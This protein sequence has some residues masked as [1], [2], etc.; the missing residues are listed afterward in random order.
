MATLPAKF[1]LVMESAK[2]QLK[3]VTR[4]L[5]DGE[6]DKGAYQG[7]ETMEESIHGEYQ[8]RDGDTAPTSNFPHPG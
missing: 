8:I 6:I 2:T 1:D 7:S 4:C 3:T 5:G